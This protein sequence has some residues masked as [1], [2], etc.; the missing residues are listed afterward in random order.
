MTGTWHTGTRAASDVLRALLSACVLLSAVVHLD[1]WAN[2]MNTL[3]VVGPAFLLNGVGG[4]VLG[5]LVLVWRHWLPL[6]G[7]VGFGVATLAAFVISTTPG[8]FF[9]VHERWVGIPVWLSA[10]SEIG[11]IVLG[12]AAI[13]VRTWAISTSARPS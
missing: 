3:D 9:G 10:I 8:G 7:A 11:A 6:L 4:L 5:V 13:L 12:V 1:L 2:G